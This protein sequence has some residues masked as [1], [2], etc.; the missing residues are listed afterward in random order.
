MQGTTIEL[1]VYDGDDDDGVRRMIDCHF[2]CCYTECLSYF[3]YYYPPFSLP[4]S[5]TL[6]AFLIPEGK[7]LLQRA[8]NM[9]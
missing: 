3:F 9:K 7:E 2:V 6:A 5:R 1:F 4:L 8:L